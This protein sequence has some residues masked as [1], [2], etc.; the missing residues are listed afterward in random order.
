MKKRLSFL[1]AAVLVFL[2]VL[3]SC[4]DP[5]KGNYEEISEEQAEEY[6]DRLYELEEVIKGKSVKTDFSLLTKDGDSFDE[7]ELSGAVLSDFSDNK[8]YEEMTMK[9]TTLN[10]TYKV[11]LKAYTDNESRKTLVEIKASAS[12]KDDFSF[13]GQIKNEA[14]DR[15]MSMTDF[16]SIADVLYALENSLKELIDNRGTKIYAD[17]DKVKV[18]IDDTTA[19]ETTEK[20]EIYA[21]MSGDDF[22][23]KFSSTTQTN[24]GETDIGDFEIRIVKEKVKI[25][26]SGYETEMS[27]NQFMEVL[28]TFMGYDE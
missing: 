3:T 2:L 5:Y 14:F 10:G 9:R 1:L 20:G 28:T 19:G 23:C 15:A 18:I 27:A 4:G 8:V 22:R 26:T 17:G 25:P 24:S 21:V 13:K 7:I 12:G 11:S 6:L 16:V